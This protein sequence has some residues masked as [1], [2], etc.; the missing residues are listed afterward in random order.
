MNLSFGVKQLMERITIEVSDSVVRSANH[1]AAQNQQRIEKVLSDWLDYVVD[2]LPVDMLPDEE[3]LALT[4][5]Q[6]TPEQQKI[7][8]VLLIRNRE[9]TLDVEERRRLDEIM[10]IYERGLLRKAQALRVAVQRKLREPLQP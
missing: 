5:L 6:L 3:V 9:G 7:L 1:V 8:N 10:R 2:E 4:E